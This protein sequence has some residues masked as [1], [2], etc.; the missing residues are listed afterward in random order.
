MALR[1]VM[2]WAN[3]LPPHGASRSMSDS[4]GQGCTRPPPASTVSLRRLPVRAQGLT[5]IWDGPLRS[6]RSRKIRPPG[7]GAGQPARAERSESTGITTQIAASRDCASG[8]RRGILRVSMAAAPRRVPYGRDKRRFTQD[9]G[10][11]GRESPPAS[12]VPKLGPL[13]LAR[14][15]GD[16]L[17]QRR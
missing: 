10:W 6:R 14:W 1:N 4:S 8:K 11:A 16:W 2:G 3:T 13:G 12:S 7:R 15:P 17:G 9:A 5:V